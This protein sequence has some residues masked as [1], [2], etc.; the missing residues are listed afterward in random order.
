V[1]AQRPQ[2]APPE[3]LVDLAAEVPDVHLDHVGIALEVV[4]PDVAQQFVLGHDRPG[5]AQQ[6][7][8][9]R[10]LAGREQDG[11]VAP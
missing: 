4:A 11:D 8:E 2:R 6:R 10:Q 5:I 9:Q 1:A 7:F 3:R